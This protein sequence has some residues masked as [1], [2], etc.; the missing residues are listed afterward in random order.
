MRTTFSKTGDYPVLED[1][2]LPEGE[3]LRND[4]RADLGA[5]VRVDADYLVLRADV[6]ADDP[7]QEGRVGLEFGV[8]DRLEAAGRDYFG[9]EFLEVD[10]LDLLLV[11]FDVVFACLREADAQD[12][13]LL[14]VLLLGLVRLADSLGHWEVYFSAGL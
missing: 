14:E 1:F 3:G 6:L 7:D 4:Q 13:G 12:L 9:G 11:D 8:V 2:E 10:D 5:V